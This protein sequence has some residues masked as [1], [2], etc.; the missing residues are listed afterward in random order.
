MRPIDDPAR[1]FFHSSI[2]DR[3]RAIFEAGIALGA[4]YH[5]FVGV[6]IAKRDDVLR[7]IKEAIEKSMSIQ[8]FREKVEVDF[9]LDKVKGELK[10]PYDYS[11]LKGNALDVRVIIRYGSARVKARMCYIDEL[12]F[13]LM[14]IED[15]EDVEVRQD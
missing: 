2:T 4:L 6:P 15:V 11:T 10:G 14:Y 5:Q 1:K 9:K 3:E 8:P 7:A 13:N 12:G